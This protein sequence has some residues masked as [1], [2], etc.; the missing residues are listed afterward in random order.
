MPRSFDEPALTPD[1]RRHEI[2]RIVHPEKRVRRLGRCLLSDLAGEGPQREGSIAI[3]VAVERTYL[4]GPAVR[5]TA[6][7]WSDPERTGRLT[8]TSGVRQ[9]RAGSDDG[10][11]RGVRS[12]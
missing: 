1:Q 4:Q 9:I 8:A 5:S 6:R 10:A 11:R 7:A 12:R 3:I 2:A